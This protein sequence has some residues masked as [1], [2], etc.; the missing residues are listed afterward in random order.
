MR[1][2]AVSYLYNPVYMET[3][4]KLRYITY[5]VVQPIVNSSEHIDWFVVIPKNVAFLVLFGLIKM[6]HNE[7]PETYFSHLTI[8]ICAPY[9]GN[10]I[11]ALC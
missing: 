11:K 10:A 6:F 3:H 2:R 1:R 7:S 4:H 8:L 9:V 5:Q